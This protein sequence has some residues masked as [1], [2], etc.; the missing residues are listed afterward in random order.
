[1]S[2]SGNAVPVQPDPA[3]ICF[4][5]SPDRDRQSCAAY[6]Q[7]LGRPELARTLSSRLSSDEIEAV[8][9]LVGSLMRTHLS[10]EEYH[11]LFLG[12]NHDHDHSAG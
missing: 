2:S 1:M 7:L 3:T 10:S 11:R 4:G 8:I 6:L 5:L 12:K 9:N